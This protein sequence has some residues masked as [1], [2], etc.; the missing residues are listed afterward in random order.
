VPRLPIAKLPD[1]FSANDVG[2]VRRA[3]ATVYSVRDRAQL[4]VDPPADGQSGMQL[5]QAWRGVVANVQLANATCCSV[6]EF[7]RPA[8]AGDASTA[9][10]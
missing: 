3:P 1:C 8:V 4:E 10:Q 2:E 5:Y 7:V 6:L 9:L